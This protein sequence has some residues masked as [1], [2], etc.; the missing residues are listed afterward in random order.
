[1]ISLKDSSEIEECAALLQELLPPGGTAGYITFD[2]PKTAENDLTG[3]PAES[4]LF[5]AVPAE[6]PV[7]PQGTTPPVAAVPEPEQYAPVDETPASVHREDALATLLQTLCQR[8]GFSCAIIADD[9]GLALAE[10]NPPLD[11]DIMAAFATVLGGAIAQASH[12]LDQ[13]EANNISMDINY[14]DKAVVRKFTLRDQPFYLFIICPQDVDERNEIEL[15]MDN[16]IGI[17]GR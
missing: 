10:H 1:M 17:L 7:L 4:T 16:I 15:S 8:G 11:T 14:A 6:E 5:D 13:H 9:S 2:L 3:I 12:F